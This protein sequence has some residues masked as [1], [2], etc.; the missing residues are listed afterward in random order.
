MNFRGESRGNST[1]QSVT[2]PE[3][4]LLRKAMGKEAKLCF[5]LHAVTEN[6]HGIIVD[7]EF[8]KSVGTTESNEA[9]ASVRRLKLRGFRPKSVG[10]DKGYHNRIFVN[11]VRKQGAI[12]HAVP[13][14]GRHI[15][16]LDERTFRHK[17]F[18]KSQ[19]KRKLIE[20]CFGWFKTV[21]GFRKTRYRGVAKNQLISQFLASAYNL[22]R[23][24]RLTPALA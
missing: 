6:R 7:T 24:A 16:G 22:V 12:P 8:T 15:A 11:G 23:I 4:R 21:A 5:T 18:L 1:H 17:S 2:D 20:Q 19:R 14:T 9:V 13:A 10:A 3:A